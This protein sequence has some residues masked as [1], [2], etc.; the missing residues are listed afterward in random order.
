MLLVTL[1][2]LKIAKTIVLS[3]IASICVTLIDVMTFSI[4][5]NA[6]R[7]VIKDTIYVSLENLN[8]MLLL[9]EGKQ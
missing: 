3:K 1:G 7:H 4:A 5:R 2:C 6:H 9:C 8:Q